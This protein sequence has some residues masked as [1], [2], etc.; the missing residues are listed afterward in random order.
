MKC[1]YNRCQYLY[2]PPQFQMISKLVDKY[3][4]RLNHSTD[5]VVFNDI[6]KQ[7]YYLDYLHNSNCIYYSE[8][9]STSNEA[10]LVSKR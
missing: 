4:P 5:A 6:E 3:I 9:P 1:L 2:H 7:E 10:L 8:C